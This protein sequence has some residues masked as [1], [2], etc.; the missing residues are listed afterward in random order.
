M[1]FVQDEDAV[2]SNMLFDDRRPSLSS[3]SVTKLLF[4]KTAQFENL[5]NNAN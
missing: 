4:G 3:T 2:P 5:T 1:A